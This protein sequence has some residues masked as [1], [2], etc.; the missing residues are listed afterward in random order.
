M[1]IMEININLL[2]YINFTNC[3][4][5]G[6]FYNINSVFSSKKDCV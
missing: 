2:H 6:H 3:R 5:Y 4:N 1:L